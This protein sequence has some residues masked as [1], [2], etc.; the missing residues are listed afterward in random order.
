MPISST[1]LACRADAF[2][3]LFVTAFTDFFVPTVLSYSP[4]GRAFVV[5]ANLYLA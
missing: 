1:E 5:E 2:P 3:E 4:D